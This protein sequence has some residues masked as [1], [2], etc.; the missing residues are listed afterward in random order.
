MGYLFENALVICSFKLLLFF[1][2]LLSNEVF[3]FGLMLRGNTCL[4]SNAACICK[5]LTLDRLLLV[6]VCLC[7]CSQDHSWPH[8]QCS[9][10]FHGDES[11]AL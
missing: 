7:V 6:C 8:L 11:E 10:A 9:E 2:I 1:F 5:D 3:N 4:D